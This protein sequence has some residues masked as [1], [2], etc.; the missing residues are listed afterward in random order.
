MIEAPE[1]AALRSEIWQLKDRL[2]RI[3]LVLG[4]AL[5]EEASIKE[6]ILKTHGREP[7]GT[8][9]FQPENAP[10]RK[11]LFEA[12]DKISQEWGAVREERRRTI[13]MLKDRERDLERA[14]RELDRKAKAAAKKMAGRLL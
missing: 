1:I 4:P 9:I 11:P 2:G 3:D 14:L 7:N 8:L 5:V 10:A 13:A 12:L 6:R